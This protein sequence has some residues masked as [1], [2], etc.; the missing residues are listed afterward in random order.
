MD[1]SKISLFNIG[2]QP[3]E[4]FERFHVANT[5]W[6]DATEEPTIEQTQEAIQMFVKPNVV[7]PYQA[8]S[9]LMYAGLYETVETMINNSNNSV[10]KIAWNSATEFNKNSTFIQALAQQ[11]NLSEEQIDVLFLSASYIR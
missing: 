10:L 3:N 8:K 2:D 7:S 9:A 5:Y 1:I 6:V 11:I 4:G